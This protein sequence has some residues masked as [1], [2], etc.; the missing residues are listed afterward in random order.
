MKKCTIISLK[1][2][3]AILITASLI[4]MLAT[5]CSKKEDED[6]TLSFDD[7]VLND[8]QANAAD[9]ISGN[10]VISNSSGVLWNAGDII[11]YITNQGHYGKF[12]VISVNPTDNYKLTIKAVT[13]GNDGSVLS[14][15][16]L[17]A[18]RGTWLC[19]LDTMSEIDEGTEAEDFW[20][21]KASSTDT[22]LAP[23]FTARFL[24]YTN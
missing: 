3:F 1:G 5:S 21:Q 4:T 15:T 17:L 7:I 22:N 18:I 13:Y 14:Q 10:L 16:S 6:Q 19:D 9:M 20:L 24:R 2:M 23:K 12:E 11:L 8:I